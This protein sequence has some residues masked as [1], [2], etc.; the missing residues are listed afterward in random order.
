VKPGDSGP[1]FEREDF[2]S[3]L[4]PA[5][6]NAGEEALRPAPQQLP[7]SPPLEEGIAISR[8]AVVSL[9]VL[10]VVLLAMAFATGYLVGTS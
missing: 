4:T 3:L 10:M 8:G 6:R 9:A 1:L 7:S 2:E 5:V